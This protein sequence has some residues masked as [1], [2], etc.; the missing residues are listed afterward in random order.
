MRLAV[1][2]A[3]VEEEQCLFGVA[4]A[5]QT[6]VLAEQRAVMRSHCGEFQPKG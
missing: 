2:S 1:W 4:H 6:R 5:F 3:T